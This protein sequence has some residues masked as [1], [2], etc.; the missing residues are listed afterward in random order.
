MDIKHINQNLANNRLNDPVRNQSQQAGSGRTAGNENAATADKVTLT[1]ASS[2]IQD[3]EKAAKT[4]K[5]DNSERISAL[6]AAIQDGSYKVDA[7]K[8][9][10]KLIQTE[11]L[12]S[13]V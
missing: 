12:F 2:Q 6:K 8:V 3:L 10:N 1:S 11:A 13:R 5:P 4:A 7:E 9:A